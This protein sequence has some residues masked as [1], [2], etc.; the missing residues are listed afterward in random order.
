[1]KKSYKT[2]AWTRAEGKNKVLAVLMPRA[3]H[4]L[5]HKVVT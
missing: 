4:Q 3:E 5:K 1:M 2:P